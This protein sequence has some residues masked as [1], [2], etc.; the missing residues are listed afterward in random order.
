LVIPDFLASKRASIP[1]PATGWFTFSALLWFVLKFDWKFDWAVLFLAWS[2]RKVGGFAAVGM[3]GLVSEVVGLGGSLLVASF[4][5]RSIA[6][7]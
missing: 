6:E 3:E 1:A 4:V 5:L 2:Y 7:G